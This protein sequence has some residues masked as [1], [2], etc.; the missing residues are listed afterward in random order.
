MKMLLFEEIFLSVY[1]RVTTY[2]SGCVGIIL[3]IERGQMLLI[4]LI[5]LQTTVA[6]VWV[7]SKNVAVMVCLLLFPRYE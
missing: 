2:D 3:K 6:C 5:Q 7:L 1:S 4:V